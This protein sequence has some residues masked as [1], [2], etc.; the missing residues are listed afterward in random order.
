MYQEL[1]QRR[2]ISLDR[3]HTLVALAD[4]GSLVRASGGDAV[5]QSQF[6]RQLRELE[7]TLGCKL[8]VRKGRTLSLTDAGQELA[9]IVREQFNALAGF[10]TR[11]GKGRLVVR[12][13]A[14]ESL[15]NW[16]IIPRC[17]RLEPRMGQTYRLLNLRTK[18][19]IEGLL[20]HQL[21][22][23]VIRV[24]GE[25]PEPLKSVVLG[26]IEYSL[27]APQ[28]QLSDARKWTLTR[29]HELSLAALQGDP[30]LAALAAAGARQRGWKPPTVAFE[31]TSLPQVHELVQ[32]GL[33][34]G[35]LP[36]IVESTFDSASV[37]NLPLPALKRLA[38][39]H[40]LVW[41]P[42]AIERNSSLERIRERLG[43]RLRLGGIGGDT[44]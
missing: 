12:I 5:R 16:L 40:H 23:G 38:E 21:D 22:F 8:T 39:P 19:V 9:G 4:A 18:D 44:V 2:G 36:S 32:Q 28:S 15:L 13:G 27:F 34:A 14:G 33:A 10:A 7:G 31:C 11:C 30:R 25:L 29:L 42:R 24:R 41:H 35:F 26:K 20:E 1:L 6:S 3:L 17:F 37:T 43:E